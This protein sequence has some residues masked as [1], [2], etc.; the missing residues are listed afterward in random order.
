MLRHIVL[1]KIHESVDEAIFEE[2]LRRLKSLGESNP[3][4]HEWSVAASLDT[5]KGRIIVENAVITDQAALERFRTSA[6]HTE[7]GEF[8][9]K[10]SDWLVGDY[11]EADY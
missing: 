5:R 2:A 4:I 6:Q 7:A 3:E 8:M 1:F 9:S 11:L 10:I